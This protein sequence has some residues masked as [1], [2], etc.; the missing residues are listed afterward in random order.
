MLWHT[1]DLPDAMKVAGL[2]KLVCSSTVQSALQCS[3]DTLAFTLRA[4]EL[5]IAD[6]SRTDRE[7]IR[8]LG[9]PLEQSAPDSSRGATEL[10]IWTDLALYRVGWDTVL[11][12]HH[13]ACSPSPHVGGLGRLTAANGP[14]LLTETL[15]RSQEHPA[16]GSIHRAFAIGRNWRTVASFALLGRGLLKLRRSSAAVATSREGGRR[17]SAIHG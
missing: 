13:I 17:S 6:Q 2:R 4:V 14:L 16:Y 11:K 5:V 10:P 9:H 12:N 15:S 7:M 3:S 8:A 1:Y